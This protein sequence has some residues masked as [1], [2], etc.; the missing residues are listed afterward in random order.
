MPVIKS[1]NPKRLEE[2][3]NI[4]D[5]KLTK[6]EISRINGSTKYRLIVPSFWQD[7][8]DYPFEKVPDAVADPFKKV[9]E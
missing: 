4:F 1:I 6:D 5:F 2:N 8:K 3:I 9:K 7:H